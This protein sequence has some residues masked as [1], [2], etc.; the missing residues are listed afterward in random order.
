MTIPQFDFTSELEAIAE[1]IMI[2]SMQAG[3]NSSIAIDGN[4]L[5]A[6]EPA[7]SKRKGGK[8]PLIE[9]GELRSS[10]YYVRLAKNKV[11][12]T[13]AAVRKNIGEYLQIDG[14]KTKSGVKYYRFF[15]INPTM[16]ASAIEFMSAKI[17]ERINERKG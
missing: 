3:I 16:N 6:N 2:P 5:P 9:T 12:I 17:K 1:R 11:K 13:L 15:G 4:A 7:T 8:P 14:V 10:F